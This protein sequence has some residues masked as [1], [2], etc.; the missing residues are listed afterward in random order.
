MSTESDALLRDRIGRKLSERMTD[1]QIEHLL[2]EVLAVTKR[3]WVGVECKSCKTFQRV[4]VEIPD[5]T[6]VTKSLLDLANQSF[7][8]PGKAPDPKVEEPV[9]EFTAVDVSALDA[10]ALRRLAA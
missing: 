2:S 5:A 9:E 6:A 3:A 7:G 8:T 10:E 4:Q 1:D